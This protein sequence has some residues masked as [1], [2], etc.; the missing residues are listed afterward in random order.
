MKFKNKLDYIL[1]LGFIFLPIIL[2]LNEI[3]LKQYQVS[4]IFFLISFQVI[5]SLIILI[6]S[7]VIYYALLNKNFLSEILIS[8]FFIFYL[9]FFYKKINSFEVVNSFDGFHYLLD[10]IITFIIFIVFYSLVFYLLKKF[11]SITKIFFLNFIIFNIIYGFYNMSPLKTFQIF[12]IETSNSQNK[13]EL[14]TLKPQKEEEPIDVYLIVLDGMISLNKA[15]N[16]NIIESE[17]ETLKKL[18]NNNYNYNSLYESNYPVS[19]ASIQALLYSYYPITE[20]TPRYKNILSFYPHIMTNKENFFYKIV[21]KLNMNFFWIGNKWGPCKGLK[22][23]ECF[24]NYSDKKTF[25]S[26]LIFSS[27]LFYADSIYSYFFNYLNKDIMITAFDFLRNG[28][29]KSQELS[30]KYNANFFL[31][32]AWKP[33]KP[34]N[35]DKNCND[36]EPIKVISNE[37]KYYKRNYNCVLDTVLNWDKKFLNKS[38]DNIVIVLGDHGWSFNHNTTSENEFV[39]S[40]NKDVFFAYKIPN[41]CNEIEVPNSH[42]NVMRFIFRCLKS[43]NPKYL[44]DNQYFIRNLNHKDYGKTIKINE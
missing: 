41:K 31:V 32:H 43:S 40:R 37:I 20:N 36:I 42:V 19:Y 6:L 30:L 29:Y 38:K 17:T 13:I 2:H 26:K 18:K 33:H 10:N 27:E 28:E 23:G 24:F 9:L 34:Y 15:K 35:L 4:T 16:L 1:I 39:K 12:S 22:Y 3:N 5:I 11:N 44:K 8:N 14:K 7:F 21:D 25:I